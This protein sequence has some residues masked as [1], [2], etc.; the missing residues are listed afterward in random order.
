MKRNK[1]DRNGRS[2]IKSSPLRNP[3][4]SLD[5][6]RERIFDDQATMLLVFY[7]VLLGVVINDWFR[8]YLE[9]PPSPG[10]LTLLLVII[11]PFVFWR[12][13]KV[14]KKLGYL[15]LGRDGERAVGQ[16]LD[17]FWERGYRVLHDVVGDNF[18]IDHV[19]VG[20]AGVFTV[21]TKTRSKPTKGETIIK[22]NCNEIQVG[23]DAP[24]EK[25]LIQSKAQASWLRELIEEGIGKRYEIQP[26]VVYPGWF[27]KRYP[28]NTQ[29]EVLVINPKALPAILEKSQ[30]KLSTEE[31]AQITFHLKRYIRATNK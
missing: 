23:N 22:Y 20:P 26:V 30:T 16:Y 13:A 8:W 18:N 9:S 29:C 25:P 6:E 28:K 11:T 10:T 14:K 17:L 21:E 12:L 27:I 24:T 31:V 19:L 4:Q 15:K 7:A 1:K 2:P 3:G 5:E